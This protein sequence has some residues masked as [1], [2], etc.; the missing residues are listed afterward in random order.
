MGRGQSFQ[1]TALKAIKRSSTLICKPSWSVHRHECK[2]KSMKMYQSILTDHGSIVRECS[3][4]GWGSDEEGGD[5]GRPRHACFGGCSGW[6]T[7]TYAT[8]Y[9]KCV[10]H[11]CCI[12]LQCKFKQ[13]GIN[14]RLIL[15][16]NQTTQTIMP[17][18]CAAEPD[19]PIFF[20]FNWECSMVVNHG[21]DFT[22]QQCS[23]CSSK[24]LC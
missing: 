14:F 7:G 24:S 3:E 8:I 18:L 15:T 5:S 11:V 6:S 23:T 17:F 9:Q 10:L 2:V 4:E 21:V 12:A 1:P 22:V 20:H 16:D 19:I 13:K